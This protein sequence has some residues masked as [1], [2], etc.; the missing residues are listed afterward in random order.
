MNE[1]NINKW[2]RPA[3]SA[4]F[5]IFAF[6]IVAYAVL[7]DLWT[8]ERWYYMGSALV[9][10]GKYPIID[11]F[12]HH[13]PLFFYI[14]AIPQKIFGNGLLVGRLTSVCMML[15]VFWL[16]YI[17]GCRLQNRTAG[18]LA[19][20]LLAMNP[21]FLRFSSYISYYPLQFILTALFFVILTGTARDSIKFNLATLVLFLI[22]LTRYTVDFVGIYA[23]CYFLCL[24]FLFRVGPK[25]WIPA[26][27]FFCGLVFAYFAIFSHLGG[28]RF[29]AGIWYNIVHSGSY[30]QIF[31]KGVL[32]RISLRITAY[33]GVIQAY[34]AVICIVVSAGL[35]YALKW[36]R[37][38]LKRLFEIEAVLFL[39]ILFIAGGETMYQLASEGGGNVIRSVLFPPLC[40]L[41]GVLIV[42][43]LDGIGDVSAKR[44]MKMFVIILIGFS[45]LV[46]QKPAMAK[47]WNSSQVKYLQRVSE[48]IKRNT[49]PGATVFSFEP[50]FVAESGRNLALNAVMEVWQIFPEMDTD[51]CLRQGF[52]NIDMIKKSIAKKEPAALAIEYP[53]RIDDDEGLGRILVPYR[54]DLKKIIDENYKVIERIDFPK[55]AKNAYTDIYIPKK[56]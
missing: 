23:A 44:F 40:V 34:F 47:S 10:Q 3:L 1:N 50:Y 49:G 31:E 46:Q 7:G 12:T 28:D 9:A 21:F 54:Q 30:G 5:L 38:I 22:F 27:G 20:L 35:F 6:Q 2:F 19:V 55:F 15:G 29:W 32:Q 52:I 41:S 13:N 14:Y 42:K 26:F 45:A 36:K 53:G 48:G 11:F 51:S 24:I 16:I 8:D 39:M 25:V 33:L 43:M 56:R 18:L 17:L 4:V 37:D